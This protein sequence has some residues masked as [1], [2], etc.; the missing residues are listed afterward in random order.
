MILRAGRQTFEFQRTLELPKPLSFAAYEDAL[1]WLKQ[2][3]SQHSDMSSRLRDYL[4]R[5]SD[6][7][8]T[9]TLTDHEAIERLA[10]LIHSR[11]IAVI[12]REQRSTGSPG[13]STQTAPPAFPLSERSPRAASVSSPQ[14][15][16]D[17][18][19]FGPNTDGG[20]QAA[21]LVAAAAG[22]KPFCPE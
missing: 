2:L 13:E 21:A 9:H 18:A 17:P 6:D 10:H 3:M 7:P 20:T 15:T 16:N 1:N 14:P 22:G 19:T 4:T 8:E 11:Q 12:V 5:Y